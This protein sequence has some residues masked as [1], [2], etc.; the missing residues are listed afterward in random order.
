VY[1]LDANVVIAAHRKYYGIDQV[2]EFWEWLQYHAAEG[3]LKMPAE[4]HAE[5]KYD[6]ENPD[7]LAEWAN[8]EDVKPHLVLP[9]EVPIGL[10]QVILQNGYAPDLNDIEI[11]QIGADPF[12]IAAAGMDPQNRTVV[13]VE[14]SKPSRTRARRRIPDVCD[15]LG[16]SW[17]DEHTFTKELGFSTDWKSK[18]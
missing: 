15:D 12:L 11:E 18:A 1:L 5:I 8:S 4:I 7:P 10:M 3:A 16:V 6:K 9:D 17:I 14:V 13:T 2:P